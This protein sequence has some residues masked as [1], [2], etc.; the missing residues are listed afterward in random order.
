MKMIKPSSRAITTG[1]AATALVTLAAVAPAANAAPTPEKAG[2]KRA[3][4]LVKD[5]GTKQTAGTYLDEKS[6]SMV[7]NVT[8]ASA[9][10]AVRDAGATPRM[11]EHSMAQLTSVKSSLDGSGLMAGTSWAVD[12]KDNSVTVSTDNS[13]SKAELAKVKSAVSKFGDKVTLRQAEGT[14][15]TKITGGDA[16]WGDGGRCSLGFNVVYNSDPSKHAFLTAGHCGNAIATWTEDEG[17]QTVLGD[18][19][20][21]SFPDDDYAIVDYDSSYTDYPSTV[22]DQEITEAGTPTVGE[23]VTRRGSTTGVHD[24]QVTALDATVQYQEGTVYGLIQTTVCA[25]PGDSG[26]SLHAG[27]TAYGLTSGG[28]GDCTSGGET[29]FQPVDEVLEAYDVSIG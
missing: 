11:V 18:T 6:D 7:V 5:L 23:T 14:Y 9:A 25:E 16:I 24:G 8:S 29:F 12:P 28:S 27:S 13:V 3:S 26:G 15:S 20:A 17:G 2:P 22:G 19:T 10:D 21:S 4:T 1:I